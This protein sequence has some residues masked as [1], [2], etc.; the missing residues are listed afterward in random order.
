MTPYDTH[1]VKR[2]PLLST[3]NDRHQRSEHRRPTHP[4]RECTPRRAVRPGCTSGHP[5]TQHRKRKCAWSTCGLIHDRQL[6]KEV[7]VPTQAHPRVERVVV[8]DEEDVGLG[9][10]ELLQPPKLILDHAR[11]ALL[12]PTTVHSRPN[13][14]RHSTSNGKCMDANDACRAYYCRTSA[15]CTCTCT[16]TSTTGQP[17]STRTGQ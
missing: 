2:P 10:E 12:G 5:K 6:G 15:T 3:A 1:A 9:L 7:Q 8:P 14:S 11:H 13:S 16:C 4:P 17:R